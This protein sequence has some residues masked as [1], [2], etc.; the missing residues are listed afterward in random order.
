MLAGSCSAAK[1]LGS[2][3]LARWM[4]MGEKMGAVGVR[5]ILCGFL[6]VL[7]GLV[8]YGVFLA[9]ET[10]RVAE[11]FTASHLRAAYRAGVADA[12]VAEPSEIFDRLVAVGR[13]QGE[14]CR[15][16]MEDEECVL[17]VTWTSWPGYV[18]K[19]GSFMERNQDVW[20]TAVPEVRN[21]CSELAVKDLDLRLEQRLGLPPGD[22][23]TMFVEMLVRPDDLFRPCPDREIDDNRC[24]LDFPG[25]TDP[26]HMRWF[27]HRRGTSYDGENLYPWTRLGYTYDWGT[28][29][30]EVGFSEYV[31]RKGARVK[32]RLL[33]ATSTY[34]AG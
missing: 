13:E 33:E 23:R 27:R 4:V 12:I 11:T 5:A 30:G 29:S 20:V 15:E 8:A 17:T 26:E 14:T 1:G 21:F 24:E 34:C 16:E 31:I 3:L 18:G 22:G 32:V 9:S 19:V 6:L 2:R 28:S 7:S 25:G 10:L